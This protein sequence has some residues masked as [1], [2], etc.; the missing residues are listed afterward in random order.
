MSGHPVTMRS[1]PPGADRIES[2]LRASE[3]RPMPPASDRG[4]W[5]AVA[6]RACV[7]A[8]LPELLERVKHAAHGGPE[9]VLATHYLDF[10]RTGSRAAHSASARGRVGGLA[11]MTAVEC[12]EGAGRFMDAL[13]ELSWAAAEETSWIMPPHLPEGRRLPDVEK[14]VIDLRVATMGR[15]LAELVYLLGDRMDEVSAQWRR[16]LCHEIERQ[17]VRPYLNAEHSWERCSHNWNAVCTDGVVAA[18]LLGGLDAPTCA[19]VLA[20]AL[21][22]VGPFLRGFTPDGGCSEGPGYW[23]FGMNH[24]SA[25]AYYVHRAT[26][27]RVDL[28]ADPVL[29]RIYEY[30]TKAV[31]SD[32][33]V[34]NFSDSPASDDFRSG[35]VAWCADRL[36]VEQMVALASGDRPGLPVRT[37]LD[38]LLMREPRHFAPLAEAVLPELMVMVAREEGGLVL[39]AKGGHNGEHHNHNDVGAFIVHFAGQ[40]LICDLGR[41]EYVRDMFGPRR[42]ELLVTRSRGHNVPLI[43]GMEQ[44]AGSEWQAREFRPDTGSDAARA[45]MDLTGAYPA[46]AGL[47]SL[48]RSLTLHRSSMPLVE[49]RDSVAFSGSDRSYELPLYTEGAFARSAD[50]GLRAEGEGAALAVE[51]NPD[52]LQPKVERVEHGDAGLE[53]RFGPALSRCTFRL[54]GAPA[55]ADVRIRFVP[56]P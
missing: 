25:L 2:M 54:K 19:R 14:P 56:L 21:Q 41:G 33:R 3:F 36:G 30:P 52:V 18:A 7:A 23:R 44:P 29:P 27:G 20:K 10:F 5:R 49:L 8:H 15:A 13:L 6:D 48:R 9:P 45:S 16:R 28:L 42:Y 53:S 26:G 31:L 32:R 1:E 47:E 50:G 39:A 17:V 38:V 37:V 12:I 35:P 22:S 55:E 46:E 43:N 51:W 34:V 40:S 24:F 4:A 11:L